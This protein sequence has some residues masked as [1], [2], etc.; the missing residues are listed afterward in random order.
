MVTKLHSILKPFLLRRVKTD[1]ESALPGKLEVVLYAPMTSTQR[2]LNDQL[3]KTTLQVRQQGWSAVSDA[4]AHSPCT[5]HQL[6]LSVSVVGRVAEGQGPQQVERRQPG[7]VAP[8]QHADAAAQGGAQLHCLR[9][10]S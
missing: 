2:K 7:R 8:Q 4:P 6:N 3:L 9:V 1:V 10:W 5:Q